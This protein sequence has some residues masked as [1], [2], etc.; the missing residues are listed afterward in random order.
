MPGDV[1]LVRYPS[2]AALLG[3]IASDACRAIGHHR[4]AALEDSRLI[5]LAPGTPG[6]AR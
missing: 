6:F 5:A 1:L 2:R 3:M 4:A